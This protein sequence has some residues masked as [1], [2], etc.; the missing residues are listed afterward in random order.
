MIIISYVKTDIPEDM[1]GGALYEKL[2][3]LGADLLIET[4][5]DIESGT[6]GQDK[7]GR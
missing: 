7:A 1:T 3:F 2:A 5:K 6:S 4:I